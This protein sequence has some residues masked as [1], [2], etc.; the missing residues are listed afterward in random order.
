MCLRFICFKNGSETSRFVFDCILIRWPPNP[1]GGGMSISVPV[2]SL[3]PQVR[4]GFFDQIRRDARSA[5]GEGGHHGV[6]A[7]G[8]D[9]TMNPILI[10][11]DLL[12][13][14]CSE[15]PSP[16]VTCEFQT[17]PYVVRSFVHRKHVQPEPEGDA[18]LQLCQTG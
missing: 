2:N 8:G 1:C 9:Q 15:N 17:T 16:L 18:L 10:A 4:G 3:H 12:E 6:I 7:Q 14:R 5:K 11:L 13:C